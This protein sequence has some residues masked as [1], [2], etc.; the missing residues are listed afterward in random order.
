MVGVALYFVCIVVS[1]ANINTNMKNRADETKSN[2]ASN[3]N[4]NC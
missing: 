2:I 4:S 1:D 3:Y